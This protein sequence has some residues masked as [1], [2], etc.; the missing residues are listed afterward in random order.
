MCPVCRSVADS[1][2]GG[3][4]ALPDDEIAMDF[5]ELIALQSTGAV[6]VLTIASSGG[7]AGLLTCPGQAC[8][9]LCNE[10]EQAAARCVDCREFLCELHQ[11]AH[12]KGRSTADHQVRQIRM[13]SV[14]AGFQAPV[15]RFLLWMKRGAWVL[16]L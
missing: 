3:V 10:T 2:E 6:F 9:G 12:R 8:C 14:S 4:E 11:R 7:S 16:A 13:R 1:P 15:V 5:L